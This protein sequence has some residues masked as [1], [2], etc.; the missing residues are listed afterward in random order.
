MMDANPVSSDSLAH[1]ISEN[2]QTNLLHDLSGHLQ[3]IRPHSIQLRRD[4][5]DDVFAGVAKAAS[6]LAVAGRKILSSLVP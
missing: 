4:V 3:P 5:C 6:V 2:A 1:E